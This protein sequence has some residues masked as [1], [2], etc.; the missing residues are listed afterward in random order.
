MCIKGENKIYFSVFKTQ[1]SKTGIYVGCGSGKDIHCGLS[2]I[3]PL[4]VWFLQKGRGRE[5]R[6]EGGRGRKKR[7]EKLIFIIRNQF[8]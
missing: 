8:M 2:N 5:R 1:I 7:R 6:G 4:L 3:Q